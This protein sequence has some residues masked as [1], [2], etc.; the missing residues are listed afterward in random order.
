MYRKFGRRSWIAIALVWRYGIEAVVFAGARYELSWESP[1]CARGVASVA[2][3]NAIVYNCCSATRQFRLQHITDTLRA[4]ILMLTGMRW[5][6]KHTA[7]TPYET[8]KV[9]K[10]TGYCWGGTRG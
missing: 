9:G 3:M 7:S 1:R 4:D 5:R 8:I 2:P 6:R 10:Y